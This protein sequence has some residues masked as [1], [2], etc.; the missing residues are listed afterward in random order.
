MD[1]WTLNKILGLKKPIWPISRWKK[2]TS[3]KGQFLIC[4]QKP[5]RK[6][7]LK[8]LKNASS[9]IVFDFFSSF[10]KEA[11]Y[12]NFWNRCTLSDSKAGLLAGEEDSTNQSM[13]SHARAHEER[14]TEEAARDKVSNCPPLLQNYHCW[15]E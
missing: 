1:C 11:T 4:T 15:K 2:F 10:E 7:G 12:V 14:I 6:K 5:I 8:I 3:Q 9:E 13:S